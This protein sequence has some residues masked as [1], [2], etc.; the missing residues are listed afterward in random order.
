MQQTLPRL[1]LLFVL[2]CFIGCQPDTPPSISFYHWKT[3]AKTSALQ[4][5]VLAENQVEKIYLHYFDIDKVEFDYKREG[6]LF[7]VG[8]L[9]EVDD[10]YDQFEIIPV[11]FIVNE[12]IKSM[13]NE[14]V[15]ANRILKLVQEIHQT[16]FQ[17]APTEIQLDCDW[18][19]STRDA[20]FKL[21]AALKKEIEVTTTIRLHQVKFAERTGVPPV[22]KGTLMVYNIGELSNFEQNSILET[23]ILKDYIN[24][25]TSYPIPLDIALPIYGQT[26]LKNNKGKL[27]LINGVNRELYE[28]DTQY[29]EQ[30]GPQTFRVKRDTLLEGFYLYPG[31]ELKLES[32]ESNELIEAMR[33]LKSSKLDMQ[34]L[35]FYHL[36]DESLEN[37]PLE[38]LIPAL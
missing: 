5:K 1:I 35:I 23:S 17:K 21:V 10:Y 33:I 31:Y 19:A 18:N 24:A 12:A 7:P 30:I 6:G 20:F 15:L 28:T 37:C 26:V 8:T 36:D 27:K 16:H 25:S 38:T 22:G 34:D 9:L 14:D 4:Q 29:F 13:G 3:Q 11:V 32:I 2:F